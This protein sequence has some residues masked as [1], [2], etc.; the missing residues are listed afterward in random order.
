MKKLNL[1]TQVKNNLYEL[2]VIN[3][4]RLKLKKKEQVKEKTRFLSII[5]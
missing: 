2:I 4:S 1:F 5:I 3:E